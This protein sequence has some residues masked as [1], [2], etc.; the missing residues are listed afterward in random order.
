METLG[1]GA[2]LAVGMALGLLGGGGSILMVPILVYLFRLPPVLATGYSL[3]AVGMASLVGAWQYGHKGLLAV[4]IGIIFALPS[5]LGVLIARRVFL[6]WLPDIIWETRAWTLTKDTAIM[7]AFAVIMVLASM[8]M[9]RKPKN[10]SEKTVDAPR[11]MG[12]WFSLQGLG[13]GFVTGVLGAGGGFLI[14]PPL[15]VFGGL[16]MKTAV[17]TSLMIIAANSLWGFFS[18]LMSGRTIEWGFLLGVTSIAVVGIFVGQRLAMKIP[19]E[20]LKKAFG[21]FVLGMGILI[22]MRQI[23]AT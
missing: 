8:A 12:V 13:V 20:P 22:L 19:N 5:F 2:F 18:D 17:G 11:K 9:L 21:W 1:Y 15:V 14:V 16:N 7:G 3:F 10:A 4:R 23:F 6:S